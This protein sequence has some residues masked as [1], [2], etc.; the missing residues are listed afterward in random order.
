MAIDL[1]PLPERATQRAT[2]AAAPAWADRL[3]AWQ[4]SPGPRERML[5][6]ERLLLLLDTGVSL[7]AGLREL[8]AQER[9]VGVAR[10][11]DGLQADILD[12][13]PLSAA[14]ARQ[15]AMF[16]QT[17]VNLVAAGE[18]GGF[19][20]QV[21]QQLLELDEKDARLR[22][23]LGSALSYPAF[24]I[25]FSM[26]TI[27]FVL[28]GVF[29]KFAV[30]FEQIRDDLPWTTRVL[31]VASDALRLHWPALLAGSAVALALAVHWL[32][33]PAT[34]GRLDALKLRLPGLRQIFT[35]IYLSQTL[36]VLGMSL[37]HGVPLVEALRACQDLVRNTVFSRFMADLRQGVNEGGGIAAGFERASFVPPMVRQMI[38]TG[39]ETGHLAQ[40]MSRV[41]DFHERELAKR[42]ALVSRL[43]EPVMLLV[44]GALVGLIVASLILPIFKLSRSIH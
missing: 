25:L 19:L 34:R 8:R 27:V 17:Y 18:R 28:V 7:H 31:M 22:A 9:H 12:G 1:E 20:P 24:L 15:S 13:Q 33:Q 32:R 30:L 26:A 36:R 43:I 10:V 5:F 40:V 4:T 23:M 21:L 14:L 3:A 42:L 29:P 6:T 44:M 41:A 16:P 2:P 37:A 35:E 11:L 39:E 38:R